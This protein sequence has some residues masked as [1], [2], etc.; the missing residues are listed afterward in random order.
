MNDEIGKKITEYIEKSGDFV[1]ENLPDVAK[2]VI[3]YHKIDSILGIIFSLSILV[4]CLYIFYN[5]L[6]DPLD[7]YDHF[8]GWTMIKLTVPGVLFFPL[9]GLL[10]N[11]VMTLLKIIYSP[12]Y[13]LLGILLDK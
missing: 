9:C 12:K 7:K 1:I 11:S 13:F 6:S 3:V 10:I 5:S 8:T 2:E 4:I